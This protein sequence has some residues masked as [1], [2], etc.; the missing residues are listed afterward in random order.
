MSEIP[1]IFRQKKLLDLSDYSEKLLDLFQNSKNLG[2]SAERK[3]FETQTPLN[4]Y[5]IVYFHA[6]LTVQHTSRKKL[7]TLANATLEARV[8]SPVDVCPLC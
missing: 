5:F 7:L 1:F 2:Q 8:L 6:V 3:T 4:I